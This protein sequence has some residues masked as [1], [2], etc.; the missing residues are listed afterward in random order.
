MLSCDSGAT[1]LLGDFNTD[2]RSEDR[3]ITRIAGE[4]LDLLS[5]YGH[6]LSNP[7]YST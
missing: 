2:I 4:Y 1:A 3:N 6:I 7:L 5:S